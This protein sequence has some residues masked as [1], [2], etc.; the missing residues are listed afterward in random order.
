[1]V[2]YGYNS[3]LWSMESSVCLHV[4]SVDMVLKLYMA[5]LIQDIKFSIQSA[6]YY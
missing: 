4:Y 1:M 5:W 6:V 2:N 3:E